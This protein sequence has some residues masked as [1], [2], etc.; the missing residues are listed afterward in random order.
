MTSINWYSDYVRY[1]THLVKTKN[2]RFEEIFLVHQQKNVWLYGHNDFRLQLLPVH[3]HPQQIMSLWRRKVKFHNIQ[4]LDHYAKVVCKF[5]E[6]SV[7]V[8]FRP[9]MK[10]FIIYKSVKMKICVIRRPNISN[11]VFVMVR[12]KLY[13]STKSFATK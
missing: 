2:Y 5:S 1:R 4:L 10:L 7:K 12:S 9:L 6:G 3:F 11:K 13:F 8:L